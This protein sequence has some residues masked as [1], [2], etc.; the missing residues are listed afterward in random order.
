MKKN[1]PVNCAL[2]CARRICNLVLLEIFTSLEREFQLFEIN[3]NL[4]E[5]NQPLRDPQQIT[6]IMLNRFWLLSKNPFVSC[7]QRI[8]SS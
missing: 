5:R 1:Y 8:I 6:F 4:S 2:L 3:L 7:C